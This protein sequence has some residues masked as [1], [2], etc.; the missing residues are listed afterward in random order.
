MHCY[1]WMTAAAAPSRSLL[2]SLS[3]LLYLAVYRMEWNAAMLPYLMG[4][5]G[6][7]QLRQQVG[8]LAS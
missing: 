6:L 4:T 1:S 5:T 3:S 7:E 8:G 2:S